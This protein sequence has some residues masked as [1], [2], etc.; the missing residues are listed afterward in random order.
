MPKRPQFSV[1]TGQMAWGAAEAPFQHPARWFM[2]EILLN[3][4]IA[5]RYFMRYYHTARL[6]LRNAK[7]DIFERVVW[8]FI[9]IKHCQLYS[10]ILGARHKTLKFKLEI[11]DR[12]E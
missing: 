3:E 8:D 12:N 5:N 7:H 1:I 6:D 11:C 4:V 9:S 2:G 10:F